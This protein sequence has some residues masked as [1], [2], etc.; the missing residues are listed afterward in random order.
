MSTSS[1][2]PLNEQVKGGPG[3]G[4]GK[5]VDVEPGGRLASSSLTPSRPAEKPP[6]YPQS[7]HGQQQ[8]DVRKEPVPW[9][10]GCGDSWSVHALPSFL[11]ADSSTCELVLGSGLYTY[12]LAPL[13]SHLKETFYVEATEFPSASFSGLISY[14]VSLVEESRDPVSPGGD[15]PPSEQGLCGKGHLSQLGGGEGRTRLGGWSWGL[16]PPL[17]EG[18]AEDR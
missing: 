15:T 11:E 8:Q 6:P 1:K 7:T 17:E 12:T 5:K 3:A 13:D 9:A 16:L 10:V 2:M 18:A 4:R 14:S